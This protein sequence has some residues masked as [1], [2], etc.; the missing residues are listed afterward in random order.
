MGGS[1][2]FEV[3]L[4]LTRMVFDMPELASVGLASSLERSILGGWTG[5]NL[6]ALMGSTLLS[7]DFFASNDNEL[8][9]LLRGSLSGV[10]DALPGLAALAFDLGVTLGLKTSSCIDAA[11]FSFAKLFP[12]M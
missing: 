2:F 5:A 1:G 11:M 9:C 12:P 3:P 7:G 10:G 8:A 4:G 6:G